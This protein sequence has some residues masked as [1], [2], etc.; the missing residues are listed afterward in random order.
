[1]NRTLAKQ[2][3]NSITNEQLKQMFDNAKVGIYDWTKV[4]SVNKG[5]TKGSAWNILYAGF[6][7]NK[8]IHK[9][10]KIN[11]IREFGK[12]LPAECIPIKTKKVNNIIP[13]H[14]DP[15]F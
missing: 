3:A 10:A 15:I 6:D 5:M 1:M 4:S 9:L 11:M 13:V 8:P 2:I 7:I 12:F 14:R